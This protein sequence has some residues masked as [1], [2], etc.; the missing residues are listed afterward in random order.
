MHKLLSIFNAHIKAGL[1]QTCPQLT[2]ASD[3]IAQSHL[4]SEHYAM[5]IFNH[6]GIDLIDLLAR[7]EYPEVDSN[8]VFERTK[9]IR[10]VIRVLVRTHLNRQGIGHVSRGSSD[11][12]LAKRVLLPFENDFDYLRQL[13][14]ACFAECWQQAVEIY[15]EQYDRIDR[16][17]IEGLKFLT[18]EQLQSSKLVKQIGIHDNWAKIFTGIY[19]GLHFLNNEYQL[20]ADKLWLD[21]DKCANDSD[22]AQRLVNKFQ[23]NVHQF[24]KALAGSFLADLG[25]DGFVKPDTHVISSI[26]ALNN[27]ESVSQKFAIEQVYELSKQLGL[28]PRLIDKIFYIG[29]SGKLYLFNII[30]NNPRGGKSVFLNRLRELSN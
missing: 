27:T 8:L 29:C 26:A 25:H 12:T 1:S 21:M 18:H 16:A 6:S 24:G 4:A 7:G 23:K 5:P 11:K 19:T 2:H 13:T 20:D 14:P 30:I 17:S 22:A 15:P 9:T 3:F 10:G 28:S